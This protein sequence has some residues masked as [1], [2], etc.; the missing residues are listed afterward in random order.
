MERSY[1]HGIWARR[2][3]VYT[4]LVMCHNWI[5]TIQYRFGTK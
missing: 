5:M 4:N 3:T 2:H 1:D